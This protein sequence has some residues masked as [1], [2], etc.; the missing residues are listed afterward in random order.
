MEK[1][2]LE[3]YISQGLSI[4]QISKKSGKSFT[5]IRYWIDK[6]ELKSEKSNKNKNV[7]S[8]TCPRCKKLLEIKNFYKR[9]DKSGTTSYCKSCVNIQVL[10]RVRKF[11]ALM[12]EYKGG[13]CIRCGYR[14]YQGAL[15]FH[16]TD[17]SEKD[18]SPSKYKMNKFNDNIKKELDK[19]ILV[20]SN[21]HKEIH[22]ELVIEKYL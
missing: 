12:V 2:E 11:K 17:P 15:E 4:R 10:E 1:S 6:H 5:T 8:R 19:C 20:C 22:N 16:H 18:F 14:K 21:C 9:R 13:E 3:N 7:E